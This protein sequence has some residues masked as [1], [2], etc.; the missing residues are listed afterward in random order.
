MCNIKRDHTFTTCTKDTRRNMQHKI[1]S[2]NITD[3]IIHK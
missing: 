1:N 2:Q 3:N